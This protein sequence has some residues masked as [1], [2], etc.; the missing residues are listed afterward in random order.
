M[1]SAPAAQRYL[2]RALAVIGVSLLLMTAVIGARGGKH[3]PPSPATF[4]YFENGYVTEPRQ[5]VR[6]TELEAV[7]GGH[8]P[9]R[10][11]AVW[12]AQ[13]MSMPLLPPVPP[14]KTPVIQQTSHGAVHEM[15]AAYR[16]WVAV[17]RQVS[18]CKQ[19]ARVDVFVNGRR[20]YH[21][22]LVR[23]FGHWWYLTGISPTHQRLSSKPA[24]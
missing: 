16:H 6:Q 9:W 12:V 22:T 10:N 17:F 8:M 3:T 20:W 23:P 11:D 7:R 21:L 19:R 24:S 15:R 18:T 14:G 2:V 13:V 1:L 4:T 5:Q